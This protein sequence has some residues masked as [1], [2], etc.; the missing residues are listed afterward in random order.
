MTAQGTVARGRRFTAE[1][2]LQAGGAKRIT[3]DGAGLE[4]ADLLRRRFPVLAFTP[5][6]LAVV[7]GGPLV[8]R[9]Y[10]DRVVGRILPSRAEIPGEYVRALAQRNAALRKVAAG[11]STLAALAPW[12]DALARLGCELDEARAETVAAIAP[13]FTSVAAELGLPGARIEYAASGLSTADLEQRLARD[14]ERGTTGAGPHL[15]EVPLRAG[16]R[17]LRSFGSQGEQRIAVLSLILAE[18]TVIGQRIGEP[19][20]L[21]LDDVLSELDDRRREALLASVPRGCQTVVT[22]T[23]LRSLPPGVQPAAVVEVSNGTAVAR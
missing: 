2:V 12:N 17:D 1:V 14:L 11:S 6:R 4:T 10:L 13:S 16:D 21:L 20:L 18:A 5:D 9:A 22:A 7:K 8:R 15:R 23:T 3:L 19:P